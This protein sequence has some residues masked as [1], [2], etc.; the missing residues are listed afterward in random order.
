MQDKVITTQ[1]GAE[2]PTTETTEAVETKETQ[3]EQTIG[4]VIEK[5]EES[6]HETVGLAKYVKERTARQQAEKDLADLKSKIESGATNNEVND[7]IDALAKEHDIDKDFLNKLVK[8]IK[9][10]T[11]KDLEEKLSDKLKPITE[12][13][14]QAK[15]DETFNKHFNQAMEKLPEYKEVV[16]PLVIKQ[17]SLNPQ[18]ASKTWVQLIEETYSNAI[19]GKRTIEKTIPGGGKESEALDFNKARRDPAYFNEVMSNPKL[20]SEYNEK[21]LR[22]GY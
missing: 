22:S 9:V 19:S 16:N 1:E 17:L 12:K 20:K 15:I 11:E 8:T 18:N 21:M 14:K 4:E 3:T 7:D 10:Q 6:N 13:E 5:Q 2:N